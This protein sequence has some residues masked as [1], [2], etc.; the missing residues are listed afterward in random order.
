MMEERMDLSE[1]ELSDVRREL[2]VRGIVAR[3]AAELSRRAQQDVS[4]FTVLSSWARPALAAAAVLA[5]LGLSVL[6]GHRG[7][8]EEMLT[9]LTDA[10][11]VP[12]PL[13]AWLVSEQAP[14][15]ADLMIALE[16][17]R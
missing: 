1:L 10:L 8:H 11:A 15:V 5:A 9:G 17:G 3:A 12:Q 4:P 13:D 7:V 2:L 14:T 6:S 16:E